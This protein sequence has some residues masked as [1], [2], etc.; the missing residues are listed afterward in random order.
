[1]AFRALRG[2][3]ST[4]SLIE[5]RTTLEEVHKKLVIELGFS[6]S[7]QFFHELWLQPYS[8][9]M[10]DFAQLLEEL[11]NQ[12]RL[13]L[14]S[15]V[16]RYYFEAIRPLH[17]ELRHFA[18]QLVSYKLGFSKPSAQAFHAALH[19]A[20]APAQECFF[21]DDKPENVTAARMFGIHG[22]VFT[23]TQACRDALADIGILTQ[24]VSGREHR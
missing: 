1:M 18:V 11:S 24:R 14:L 10:P 2:L 20:E 15:N 8:G 12:F 16:D 23:S 13:I 22:H 9:P 3:P 4:P 21:V 6:R 5:G 19:A 17:P 7:L